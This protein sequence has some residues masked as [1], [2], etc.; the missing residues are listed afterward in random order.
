M[1]RINEFL[2][3]YLISH[4]HEISQKCSWAENVSM[5]LR[6]YSK[7]A[8]NMNMLN[9]VASFAQLFTFIYGSVL[10]FYLVINLLLCNSKATAKRFLC[11]IGIY[12]T[13]LIDWK[14]R[15][16]VKMYIGKLLSLG[17][18]L[19]C[20][21]DSVFAALPLVLTHSGARKT[22]L[23]CCNGTIHIAVI[24]HPVFSVPAAVGEG[25]GFFC[26]TAYGSFSFLLLMFFSFVL[27]FTLFSKGFC[28]NVF[29]FNIFNCRFL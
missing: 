16:L 7:K 13:K 26:F 27:H 15:T 24:F 8:W 1:N 14:L 4:S 11:C 6:G 18:F 23:F 17:L 21:A 20:R 25:S 19:K 28:M 22:P 3:S 5:W 9:C 12:A 29:F 10:T 2:V